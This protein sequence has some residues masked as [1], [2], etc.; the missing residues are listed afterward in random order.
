MKFYL[1]TENQEL[2]LSPRTGIFRGV[3]LE[4][5]FIFVLTVSDGHEK[6]MSLSP[7]QLLALLLLCFLP[8]TLS[9]PF[10]S[11]EWRPKDWYFIIY[12]LF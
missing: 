2:S 8:P 4:E 5:K 9:L 3:A 7:C 11:V 12:N 10:H 1:R 6:K